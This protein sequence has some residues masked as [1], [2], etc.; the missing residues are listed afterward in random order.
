MGASLALWAAARQP[1]SFDRVVIYYGTSSLDFSAMTARVLGHFVDDDV[2]VSD[3]DVTLLSAELFEGVRNPSCGTTPTPCTGLPSR[4]S[5]AAMTRRPRSSRG[6]EPW[7]SSRTERD[8]ASP[9]I[10]YQS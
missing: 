6:N 3:D 9:P 10:G 2:M 8:A 5:T 7:T 4:V 1:E